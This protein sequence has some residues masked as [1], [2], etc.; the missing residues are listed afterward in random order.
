MSSSPLNGSERSVLPGAHAVGKAD[1]QERLEVTVLVRR[2]DAAALRSH[3][4]AVAS[5][6]TAGTPRLSHD[7]FERRFSADAADVAAVRSF[8]AGHG[9]A[10]AHEDAARR[11]VM[12]SG[13]VA[14]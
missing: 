9:I 10:V 2:R 7:E 14:Q 1:P 3:V 5:G 6:D 4:S 13:T 8:A 12:L 11:T